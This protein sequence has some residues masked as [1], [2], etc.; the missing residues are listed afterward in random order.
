MD[1]T[2]LVVGILTD[3]LD[4][5][6]TTDMPKN[7]PERLV[8][9]DLTGDQSTPYVL[10]P[11]YSLTCWGTSDRDAHGIALAAVQALWEAAED[12]P[13]LSSCDLETMS[14]DEWSAN[15]QSRYLVEV[16]LTVN[17]E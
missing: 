4:V 8:L 15:G 11:R 5:P 3:V 2:P 9:V 1:T 13:Y 12:H 7:R 6:V 17:I 14:R 16:T 10:H